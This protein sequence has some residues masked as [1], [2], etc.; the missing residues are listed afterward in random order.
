MAVGLQ[1][2]RGDSAIEFRLPSPLIPARF[3]Q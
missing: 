1:M 3:I 2:G